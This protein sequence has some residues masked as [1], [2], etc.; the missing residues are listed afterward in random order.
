MHI[1]DVIELRS[2]T[3]TYFLNNPCSVKNFAKNT[4]LIQKTVSS[5]LKGT[6]PTSFKTLLKINQFLESEL[7]HK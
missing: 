6:S 1:I 3:V 7:K 5:F 4:G 2:K